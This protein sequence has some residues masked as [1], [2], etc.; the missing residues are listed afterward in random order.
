MIHTPVPKNT[1]SRRSRLS[2]LFISLSAAAAL[3]RPTATWANHPVLV[4]GNCNNPPA[5][6]PAP[7]TPGQC[8]DYVAMA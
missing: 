4:E 1:V 8:G 5:G 7:V 6:N 3:M 2:A